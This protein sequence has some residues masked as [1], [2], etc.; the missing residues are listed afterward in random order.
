ML[1]VLDEIARW[2][3]NGRRV[4][5]ARVVDVAG[6]GPREPGAAMAVN[7]A[8]EVVGSVSGGCVEGAVVEA[9]LELLDGERAPGI[10]SFGYS[11]DDAFAVGL[12]CGGTIHLFLEPLEAEGV[13]PLSTGRLGKALR[14]HRPAALVSVV[15]GPH[16]G[17]RILVEAGRDPVGSVGGEEL[18]RVVVRDAIGELEAGRTSVRHYGARG[19]T[20]QEVVTVFVQSFA[21][22]PHMVIFGAVDFTGALARVAKVLGFR[23]TVCDARP[24][25]ATE[26]RFPMA[27]EV[28]VDWPDRYL[29]SVA[30][31]LGPRDAIC[32]L[33]HDV[34]FDVPAIVTAVRT[35]V[36]YIGA[37][38]SRHTHAKRVEKLREAGLT[39]EEIRRVRA[40]IGLDLGAR[41]P[42]ETAVAICAEIIGART[43]HGG[44]PLR[45]ASGPI[46]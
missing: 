8:S 27:D 43:D 44:R 40:P 34:K 6:S 38:G 7:D 26:K 11:D 21:P 42:E 28:L 5:I 3:A 45:D 10:V 2:R 32:V 30:D 37:M 35:S 17:A 16:V 4:A 46:H 23:V 20:G 24:V 41:T 14:E 9:A 1:E 12:T 39:D 19:E 22:P 33:T 36:G 18:D 13:D 15:E 29:G 31:R 25:F